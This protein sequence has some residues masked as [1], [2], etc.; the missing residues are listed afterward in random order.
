MAGDPASNGSVDAQRALRRMPDHMAMGVAERRTETT[1]SRRD[2]RRRDQLAAPGGPRL[3]SPPGAPPARRYGPLGLPLK[4][5]F[6]V[7]DAETGRR[8]AR[9]DVELCEPAAPDGDARRQIQR[10]DLRGRV[11]FHTAWPSATG[12][13]TP[14][15]LVR[16]RLGG[17][18]VHAEEISLHEDPARSPSTSVLALTARRGA[19]KGYRGTGTLPVA[20]SRRARRHQSRLG[21][22]Q[23]RPG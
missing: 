16:V 9:A 2:R 23:R 22:C 3:G 1:T 10:S 8:V 17:A 12:G 21:S 18:L 6:T 11:R 4:I 19:R 20:T 14:A 7:R 13:R 5:V 15:I